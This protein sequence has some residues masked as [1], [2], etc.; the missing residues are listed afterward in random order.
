MSEVS[1]PEQN[2]SG[3]NH[4]GSASASVLDVPDSRMSRATGVGVLLLALLAFLYGLGSLHILGNGDE[5]VYAQITRAT[6]ASGHWLPLA[7]DMPDMVN[8]KPPLLFWQ[9]ILSTDWGHQWTLFSLRWPSLIWTFLTALL[10]GLVAWQ[11]T[12]QNLTASLL[13]AS[14]YL[15]FLSTY[16]YGRPFLTNPPETFWVFLCFFV[17]L[18]WRPW[19]FSSRFIF[20]TVIGSIAGIALLTKSFAQLLPIGVALA[21]WHL[22]ECRWNWRTFLFQ[23]APSLAWTAVLALGIFSLWFVLDPD[24]VAIWKEFVVSENI[25][26]MSTAHS[27]YVEAMLWGRTSIWGLCLGWFLNAGLLAFPLLGTMV[28]AWQHRSE[29]TEEEKFLWILAISFFLVFCIPTQRSGRYLLEVMPAIAVLMV[30]HW[31]RLLPQAFLTTLIASGVISTAVAWISL[32]LARETSG[33][34][35][36]WY[37]WPILIGSI[38]L[39]VVALFDR[40]NWARYAVP[41]TLCVYLSLSSF[42][43]IFDGPVGRFSPAAIATAANR[44]V[45]VP[46]NFRAAAELERMLLPGAR[47]RGYNTALSYTGPENMSAGDLVLL[48]LPLREAA[49]NEAIGSRIELASRHSREQLFEM[50]QGRV[51][52]HLFCRQWL[53]PAPSIEMVPP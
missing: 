36:G 35:F 44:V 43:G 3:Q 30:I 42:A 29:A 9:G 17:M 19:S 34:I 39:P 38:A 5:M 1:T 4:S 22:Y 49:L 33:D 13:A 24:P 25:G 40:L 6:A 47:V 18:T 27:S 20:P 11:A 28:R 46:E 52:K 31:R 45:W 21:W 26:K 50:A 15:G 53:L 12:R 16:R 2:H 41:S 10:V 48:V 14:L 37:H 32:A 8:T 23:R 51:W 7:S